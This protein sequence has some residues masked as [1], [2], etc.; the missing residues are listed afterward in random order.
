MIVYDDLEPSEK[1]KVYD[2]G[3]T[4]NGDAQATATSATRC[5]S[6]T[7]PATCGRRSLEMT[8]ALSIELR[9][10]VDCIEHGTAP[11]TDGQAGLRVVRILEAATQSLAERGRVIELDTSRVHGMIPFLDLKA[12]YR[13]IKPEIDAAVL[14][15][16]E[17]GQ[18]VLGEEVA[19][20]EREF[21]AYCG[22]KHA[23]R[24]QHRHERA[25]P[26]AARRRRRARRRGHHR[27]VHLRRHRRGDLLH[28]RAAGVRR[29]RSATR[30][31]WTPTQLEAAITPRTKA[32]MPVHLYGQMADMDPILD[33]RRPPRPPGDRGRLPGH[34]A[35]YKGRRAG[36]IGD[37]GCFSFYPGKNLGAYGEGGI[38]V[39][40]ND[41]ACED[42][43]HAAR[44]GPGEALPP[45]AEGLQLPH[46]RHPG[47]H[48]AASSCATSSLDRGAPG[49]CARQ[50]D[51]LLG[52]LGVETPRRAARRPPARLPHLRGPHRRP[53]RRCSGS[54]RPTGVQTGLHY[55]IPVHLQQAHA[56]LGYGAATSRSPR[57]RPTRCCRCRCSRS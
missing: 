17:S 57:R 2:K 42:D 55:P 44:L 50:Y 8:E 33:D 26:G 22:A 31:R 29:H 53:R 56:D 5:W 49:A 11:I 20:F 39:T 30:S 34:G 43:P 13:S 41:D 10:F 18:F 24:R 7:A 12:Q 3:I 14:G 32:I 36:S 25:A 4:L 38:V 46:G 27:A 52:G 1:I 47:R 54:C 51:A 35:E 19:A 40:N 16:L 45:R 37:V 6:A 28:R 23:H 21:A 9:Q 15:V 48:P